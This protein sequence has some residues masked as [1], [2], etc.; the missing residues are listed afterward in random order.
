MID[1]LIGPVTKIL[2][3]FVADKDLKEKLQHELLIDIC[4][5]MGYVFLG[6]TL[7]VLLLLIHHKYK[8]SDAHN[9]DYIRD[10][11][12]QWFQPEDVCNFTTC[13]HEMWIIGLLLVGVIAIFIIT[14]EDCGGKARGSPG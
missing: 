7:G 1:K 2:D 8:H 3:K 11:C 13:S 5:V 6:V 9:L 12:H 4:E 14:L 10:P